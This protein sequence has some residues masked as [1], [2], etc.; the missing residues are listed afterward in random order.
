MEALETAPS[1]RKNGYASRLIRQVQETLAEQG[2]VKLY[3]HVNKGNFA[4]LRTHEG[5][6]FRILRDNAVYING[7]VDFH[8]YTL[9]Y[10][11]K[12]SCIG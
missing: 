2:D 8:S 6:G 11:K 3:S 1:Q 12:K 10:E 5:C 4:S 9:C 7:S